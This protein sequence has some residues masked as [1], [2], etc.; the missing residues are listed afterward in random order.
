ML[1]IQMV[2]WALLMSAQARAAPISVQAQSQDLVE[3]MRQRGA[4]KGEVHLALAGLY[5]KALHPT[6][7]LAHLRAARKLGI[8]GIRTDLLLGNFYR[9]SGRYDAA[10]STLLRVLVTHPGQP[11]ALV[12]LWKTVYEAKLRGQELQVDISTIRRRLATFGL[13]FPKELKLDATGQEE[14]KRITVRAYGA[15]LAQRNRYAAELFEAAITAFPSNARAH[16]GLGIARARQHDYMRAAG[17]Y[18]LYLELSPQAADASQ[19]DEMLAN[20]WRNRGPRN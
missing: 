12:Q 9:R 17:A 13:H 8:S 10:C 3:Q 19:V 18:L 16:R 2:L 6:K 4:G 15:L 7:V 5:A 14:S 1:R 20:Y 11:Y